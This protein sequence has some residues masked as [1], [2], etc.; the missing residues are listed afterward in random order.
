MRY[1][2]PSLID[3][4]PDR[5]S[6]QMEEAFHNQKTTTDKNNEDINHRQQRPA[7]QFAATRI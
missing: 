6:E 5:T 4:L 1:M 7:W 2:S 3:G